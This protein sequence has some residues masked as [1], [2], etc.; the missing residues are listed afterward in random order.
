MKKQVRFL[1]GQVKENLKRKNKMI[2]LKKISK[3]YNTGH[4][5]FQALK[6]VDLSIEQ[7]EFVAIMGPSG[8]GKSTLLH[9]L[10][11]LD[12]PDS[13]NYY[14]QDE[15][16]SS[17]EEN[18]L[19]LIR[20]QLVGF[21]F[22][23]FHL[24]PGIKAKENVG[25]PKVYAGKTKIEMDELAKLSAVGLEK[26]A[27]HVPSELSGG[28]RQRVAIARSLINNPVVIF[29]DEPTGNLDTKSEKE[30]MGIFKDLNEQGI[31]I[32][33]VT[34][35]KEVAEH[36]KR[37]IFMRDGKIV[38]DEKKST[39]IS[40]SNKEQR[41]KVLGVLKNDHK[42]FHQTEL[43]EHIRQAWR[44]M[45]V[46]KMRT[47]LSMLGVL[48]GIAAV[49]TMLALGTG[50][51]KA[52]TQDLSKLGSNL[53]IVRQASRQ[54][55]GVSLGTA[56]YARLT[57]SDSDIIK[58]L[59]S[60]KYVSGT[61]AGRAQAVFGNKNWNTTIQGVETS[62][63]KIR[64]YTPEIGRFFNTQEYVK[65]EKVALIGYTIYKELFNQENPIGKKIKINKV[66]CKVVGVLPEKGFSRGRDNDD[67]VIVPLTTAMY[68]LFGKD[69]VDRIEV[70]AKDEKSVEKAQAEIKQ[71]INKAHKVRDG[72]EF[73]D[74]RDLS[75]IQEAITN[76]VKT[77]STLLGVAAA[78]S[79][80]VGGIGIMNIMLVSVTERTREI[81]IRKA[82]GARRTDIM[83]QFLIESIVLTL[84][85]GF[86]GLILSLMVARII[87]L[88]TGWTMIITVF[89]ISLSTGFSVA[90]GIFFGLWPAKKASQLKTIDA[91]R[92][93]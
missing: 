38:S 78:I 90:V 31:T 33:M 59:D 74:I 11:F 70:E 18:Q 72:D 68:R 52:I 66:S 9:I 86:L 28:E 84:S 56:G 64:S 17:L 32:I 54:T 2:E 85:G 79:L 22:Q 29:A 58:N 15:D 76:T 60:V 20:N 67:M 35:E 30:I 47:F 71:L 25:L 88:F 92:Y 63:E 82:I 75:E 55:G 42:K 51:T 26:R 46:N 41:N 91:L 10:G 23:Q 50:A 80:L 87:S 6:N 89:S 62:Y 8:S 13:G 39:A 93:E 83:L 21:V 49:I 57:Q 77:I 45:M 14:F 69:Y 19:A 43:M 61:I 4:V 40:M 48:I 36:A 24:L 5:A 81:G 27:D 16:V 1:K 12:P 3:T 73:V 65:R 53:L 34:H 7:G 44:A 37:I